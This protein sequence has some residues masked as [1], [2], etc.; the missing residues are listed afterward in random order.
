MIIDRNNYL[1]RLV[2]LHKLNSINMKKIN[3]KELPVKNIEGKEEKIDI[4]KDV[5]N[6]MFQLAKTVVVH[7]AA[8]ALYNTGECNDSAEVREIIRELNYP[9]FIRQAIEQILK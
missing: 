3:L 4:S 6:A 5:G 8:I 1:Y 2:H 9:Y 7:E